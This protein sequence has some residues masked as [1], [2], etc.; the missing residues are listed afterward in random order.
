[1]NNGRSRAPKR[2]GLREVPALSNSK[3]GAIPDEDM[4]K[5]AHQGH[6]G[7]IKAEKR[8]K[9]GRVDR[10]I[11]RKRRGGGY[12][13]GQGESSEDDKEGQGNEGHPLKRIKKQKLALVRKEDTQGKGGVGHKRVSSAS[14][15]S[16][17]K[18]QI[19]R[20]PHSHANLHE[21]HT[22]AMQL[23]LEV[24]FG[25]QIL[26]GY[27][28]LLLEAILDDVNDVVLDTSE[29]MTILQVSS[30]LPSQA[31][32]IPGATPKRGGG[33]P[34]QPTELAAL[35][36]YFLSCLCF[37]PSSNPSLSS[38][39]QFSL[40]RPQPCL[41]S[42]L[43]VSLPAPLAKGTTIRLRVEY[44]TSPTATGLMWLSRK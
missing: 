34:E 7:D 15:I 32:P 10:L 44:H 9:K 24:D 1:M 43:R 35:T 21:V 42:A 27:V 12:V 2:R 28:E 13:E 4:D 30:V 6:L 26:V 22:K 3:K 29:D 37:E 23:C 39:L 16:F 11:K 40:D 18:K 38:H 20:D 17:K 5:K 25:K 41:G 33:P 36:V 8:K 19:F 31:T 14:S